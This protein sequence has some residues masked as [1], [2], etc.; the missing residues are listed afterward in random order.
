MNVSYSLTHF[1]ISASHAQAFA[2]NRQPQQAR[3]S[4]ELSSGSVWRRYYG[5]WHAHKERVLMSLLINRIHPTFVFICECRYGNECDVICFSTPG[6]VV[7]HLLMCIFQ[8]S[9]CWA[10]NTHAHIHTHTHAPE[11]LWLSVT[12]SCLHDSYLI[13]T[14][15]KISILLIGVCL[16]ANARTLCV[17]LQAYNCKLNRG[18]KLWAHGSRPNLA[19]GSPNLSMDPLLEVRVNAFVQ[20]H[21]DRYASK[22]SS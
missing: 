20:L 21:R 17:S 13:C 14:N 22:A 4:C 7:E 12:Q 8:I 18:V 5:S 15:D 3:G 11:R 16:C 19:D 9:V 1:P 2:E 10:Q 6:G